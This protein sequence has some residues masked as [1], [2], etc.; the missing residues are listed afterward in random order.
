M[1][2]LLLVG[3]HAQ[4]ELH[5]EQRKLCDAHALGNYREVACKAAHALR[6]VADSRDAFVYYRVGEELGL[7]WDF[8]DPETTCD[9]SRRL[10][11]V[12]S[13]LC[14][15]P[16]FGS[17]AC[18]SRELAQHLEL[19]NKLEQAMVWLNNLSEPCA[20]DLRKC[21][22]LLDAAA[23]VVDFQLEAGISMEVAAVCGDGSGLRAIAS[24][25]RDL[26]D[27]IVSTIS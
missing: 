14:R 12:A 15:P 27:A 20:E 13:V 10:D 1:E 4:A 26:V 24:G 23:A 25:L 3:H 5:C 19:N 22:H 9:A 17:A 16:L 8:S 11:H 21:A 2:T 7:Q 18:A 6:L